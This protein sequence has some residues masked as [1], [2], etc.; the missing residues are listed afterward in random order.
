VESHALQVTIALLAHMSLL[1]VQ[2]EHIQIKKQT[3]SSIFV[4][5]AQL[6]LSALMWH[7]QSA[8]NA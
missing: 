1:R 3:G 4:S 5:H 8:L 7:R 2:L 6:I